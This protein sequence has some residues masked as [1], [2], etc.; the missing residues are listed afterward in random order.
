MEFYPKIA[1]NL[2]LEWAVD[3]SY[4]LVRNCYTKSCVAKLSVGEGIFLSQLD[5]E[6]DPDDIISIPRNERF[7]MLSKFAKKGLLVS[8][9]KSGILVGGFGN[10]LFTH[11]TPV[12]GKSRTN[13][14]L[15][16]YYL[17]IKNLWLPIL[18]T[19][20]VIILIDSDVLL[21]ADGVVSAFAD[22]SIICIAVILHELG[23][24]AAAHYYGVPIDAVGIGLKHFFPC[25]F[26]SCGLLPFATRNIKRQI[27][28][29]GPATN[30]MLAGLF[31]LGCVLSKSDYLYWASLY[32]VIIAIVNLMPFS[33]LDGALFLNTFPS[34]CDNLLS[35]CNIEPITLGGGVIVG[36]TVYFSTKILPIWLGFI[37]TEFLAFA[38]AIIVTSNSI[39]NFYIWGWICA[40]PVGHRLAEL[41]S[42]I[43]LTKHYRIICIVGCTILVAASF[44]TGILAVADS[45][46]NTQRSG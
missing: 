32:N 11:L 44:T 6:T 1:D 4:I 12:L 45:I 5:G 34:K 38:A 19:C 21:I 25:V 31:F 43:D 10:I 13:V 17:C 20:G 7:R 40:L 37:I 14:A 22:I 36:L 27:V 8:S 16:L 26:I 39:V 9:E 24:T 2:N 15:C 35:L 3:F 30:I 46:I 28:I 41:L 33:G 29:A 18:I 23:H 42:V